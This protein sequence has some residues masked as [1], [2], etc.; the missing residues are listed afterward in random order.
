MEVVAAK[1]RKTMALEVQNF[2]GGEFIPA[3]THLDSFNPATGEV[4]VKI[5]DSGKEE[6]DLAVKS[7]KQA[8][9]R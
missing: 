3:K 1:K 7:A 4:W 8:F 6:I 2:I 9:P 5:P